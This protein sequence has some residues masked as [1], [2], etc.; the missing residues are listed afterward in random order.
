MNFAEI[1]DAQLNILNTFGYGYECT[2]PIN[3]HGSCNVCCV[4]AD[5]DKVACPTCGATNPRFWL[6]EYHNFLPLFVE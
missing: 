1:I 4:S 5:K 3:M 6:Q 2:F